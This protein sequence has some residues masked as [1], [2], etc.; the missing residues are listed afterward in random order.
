MT[1]SVANTTNGSAGGGQHRNAD[2]S[3]FSL[4]TGSGAIGLFGGA[5]ESCHRRRGACHLWHFRLLHYDSRAA[6]LHQR[7]SFGGLGSAIGH[8]YGHDRH[9]SHGG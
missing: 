3:C 9:S 2:G 5:S 1:V 8:S 4:P 6:G 7:R